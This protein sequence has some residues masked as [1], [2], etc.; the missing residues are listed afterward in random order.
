MRPKMVQSLADAAVAVTTGDVLPL[1]QVFQANRAVRAGKAQN[2]QF[3]RHYS[4]LD[5]F[6]NLVGAMINGINHRFLYA[7]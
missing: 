3:L 2:H 1:F 5:E 4:H 7:A 6:T